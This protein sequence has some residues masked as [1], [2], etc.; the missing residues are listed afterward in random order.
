[1]VKDRLVIVG[2]TGLGL[3]DLVA[4]PLGETVF[5][6]E[7]HAQA[8]EAILE[9]QFLRRIGLAPRIE[10]ALLVAFGLGLFILIPRTNAQRSAALQ[11]RSLDCPSPTPRAEIVRLRG[12]PINRDAADIPLNVPKT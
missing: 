4:T 10:A 1:M 8:T 9:G 7:N 3:V 6:V 2:F 11:R 12:V 5:G